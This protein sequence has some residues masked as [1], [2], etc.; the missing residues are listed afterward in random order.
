[1]INGLDEPLFPSLSFGATVQD[2]EGLSLLLDSVLAPDAEPLT[3]S[4]YL[5]PSNYRPEELTPPEFP[6]SN[7]YSASTRNM[8][9]PLSRCSRSIGTNAAI[10]GCRAVT[11][12]ARMLPPWQWIRLSG[13][14]P[15]SRR[16]PT[17]RS[18]SCGRWWPPGRGA[19]LPPAGVEWREAAEREVAWHWL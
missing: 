19:D 11:R 6:P 8:A 13:T 18:A 16:M 3:L 1:M 2:G 14:T 4:M 9:W 15:L 12:G 17:S 7:L 10:S 5:R